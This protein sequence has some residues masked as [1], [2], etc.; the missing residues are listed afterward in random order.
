MSLAIAGA[1]Y[2]RFG[3]ISERNVMNV[4]ADIFCIWQRALPLFQ[5]YRASHGRKAIRRGQCDGLLGFRPA[6]VLTL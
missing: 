3:G 6:A 2:N 4:P 5:S 1:G